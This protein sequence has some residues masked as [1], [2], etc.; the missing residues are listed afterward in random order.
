MSI[1]TYSQTSPYANTPQTTSYLGKFVYRA[2][3]ASPTDVPYTIPPE[4]EFKPR[5]LSYALYGTGAYWWTFCVRNPFL[6]TDPVWSLK[7]GITIMVPTAD[8]LRTVVGN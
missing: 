7:A 2:I 6:R 1:V 5:A 8:Y 3:P 4:Y